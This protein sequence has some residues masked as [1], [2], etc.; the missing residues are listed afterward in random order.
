M[1]LVAWTATC[2]AAASFHFSIAPNVSGPSGICKWPFAWIGS[3]I[4]EL[5]FVA[6]DIVVFEFGHN[7][8]LFY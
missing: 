8:D 4:E 6:V 3:P 5:V 1:P 7:L 2:R